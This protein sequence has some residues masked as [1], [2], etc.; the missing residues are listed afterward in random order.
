MRPLILP[1]TIVVGLIVLSVVS[2]LV[3]NGYSTTVFTTV[4]SRLF[5]NNNIRSSGSVDCKKDALAGK[6]LSYIPVG[7][8]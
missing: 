1:L 8:A 3:I 2:L 6:D 4:T 5:M 7:F